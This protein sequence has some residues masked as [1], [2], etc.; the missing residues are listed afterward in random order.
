[1]LSDVITCD[2]CRNCMSEPFITCAEC[3]RHAPTNTSFRVCLQCFASGAESG[4][5][6]NSHAYSVTH[7][8]VRLFR[9]SDWTAREERR[10]LELLEHCGFGNWTDIGKAFGT[11]SAD[12]CKQHYLD[13]YFDGIFWRMCGLTKYPYVRTNVPHLYRA[14]AIDPPRYVGDSAQSKCMAG[15]RFA[16]SDFDTP[17]DSSAELL[18][19]HLDG[20]E[21]VSEQ[22]ASVSEAIKCAMVRAYNNR[23]R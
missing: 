22:D 2:I 6:L 4:E 15:Y 21:D 8:N 23:L 10:L 17:F 7:D 16:R 9:S 18:I 3:P 13:H 20:I 14:N 19:S 11:R 12:E 5:H 1:M